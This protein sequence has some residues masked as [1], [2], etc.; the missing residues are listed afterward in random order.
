MSAAREYRVHGL[1]R[2]TCSCGLDGSCAS[3]PLGLGAGAGVSRRGGS[4]DK[5]AIHSGSTTWSAPR[6]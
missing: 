3:G 4:I 1:I 5:F 2:Y 6:G